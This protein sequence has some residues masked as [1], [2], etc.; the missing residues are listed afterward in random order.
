MLLKLLDTT[1]ED[2]QVKDLDD[3]DDS[4]FGPERFCCFCF[5]SNFVSQ[6]CAK[7]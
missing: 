2:R 5:F 6:W 4:I 3:N 7:K 1:E